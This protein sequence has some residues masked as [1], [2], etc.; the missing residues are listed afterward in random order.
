MSWNRP[1]ENQA[2]KSCSSV[3][4]S[5][6]KTYGLVAV[7]A[8]VVCALIVI[9]FLCSSADEDQAR[10]SAG[11][12]LI[13]EVKPAAAPKSKIE[14]A[15]DVKKEIP[16]WQRPTTNGLTKWQIEAWKQ[17]RRPPPRLTNTYF[18]T[19]SPE[20]FEIFPTR[21][22][23]EIAMLLTIEPGTPLIGSPDYGDWFKEQFMKSCE[24]PIIISDS[25]DEYQR[26]LKKMMRDVKIELRQRMADGE[27]IGKI[28][29]DT[30]NELQRLGIVRQELENDMREMITKKAKSGSD[31]DDYVSALNKMLEDKGMAPF[32]MS[33][34]MKQR[35]IKRLGL[36]QDNEN[37]KE[38]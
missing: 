16:Y 33:P 38:E 14:K 31:I 10:E 19:R 4:R 9:G 25:D 3:S 11:K 5:K 13:K 24:T 37:G 15:E 2:A 7:L 29:S 8:A 17:Y 21:A 34:I 23:N 27:D 1:Q 18:I 6:A 35:M 28:M 30:R 22:E 36:A 26:E 32:E 12:S 20:R